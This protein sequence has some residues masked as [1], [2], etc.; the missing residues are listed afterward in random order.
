M[1]TTAGAGNNLQCLIPRKAAEE[2]K[3]LLAGEIR[4]N[5]QAEVKIKKGSQLEFSIGNKL[6]A[7]H[8]L[9]G[10]FPNW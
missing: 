8:K 9:T 6:M 1:T 5:A 3:G 2:L 7:A 10:N 4:T